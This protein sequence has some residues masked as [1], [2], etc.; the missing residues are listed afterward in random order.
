MKGWVYVI[1]NKSMP[2]LV[3]IGYSMQD[4]ELRARELNHTGSPSPYVVDYEVLVD[5][6]RQIEQIA[7]R[8]LQ[9]KNEG[10]EWFRCSAEEAIAAIK[11]VA[12]PSVQVEN[13]KRADRAKAESIRRQ[14]DERDRL[15]VALE[16]KR[17]KI[18]DRYELNLK[19]AAKETGFWPIFGGCFFASIMLLAMFF[20]KMKDGALF[21]LS[22]IGSFIASPFVKEHF[23]EKAKQHPNYKS[24][25]KQRDAELAAVDAEIARLN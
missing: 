12:G 3:K 17:Q 23:D 11:S 13:F 10:K 7:H 5:E 15:R 8:K 1:T 14:Q 20:P 22:T 21:M 16:Q 19:A 18:F 25:T 6:P 24:L 2:G 4:P 9:A